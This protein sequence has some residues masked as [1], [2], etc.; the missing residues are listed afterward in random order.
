MK[1]KVNRRLNAG[2]YHVNFEVGDFSREE[3]QKMGSFG[4]PQILIKIGGNM[5][6]APTGIQHPLNQMNSTFDAA[7]VNEAEAKKY[8][9]SV[10]SQVRSALER[11]RESQD[12]FS[13]SEE[14]AL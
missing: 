4:V 9:E 6:S 2:L 5:T 10:L 14:V 1:I 13:S 8:E 7:F 11:L 12:K 3:I